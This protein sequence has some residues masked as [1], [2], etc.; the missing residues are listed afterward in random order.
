MIVAL[1]YNVKANIGFEHV[2]HALASPRSVGATIRLGII[3]AC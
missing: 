2:Q 3:P 1:R